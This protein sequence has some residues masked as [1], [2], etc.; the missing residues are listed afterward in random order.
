M[1]SQIRAC[2][3]WK[4]ANKLLYSVVNNGNMV[5]THKKSPHLKGNFY[6]REKKSASEMKTIDTNTRMCY[7]RRKNVIEMNTRVYVH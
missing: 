3:N 5:N 2:F 1:F 4:C 6:Y 7:C